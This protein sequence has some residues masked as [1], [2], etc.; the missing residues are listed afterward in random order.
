MKN[1]KLLFLASSISWGHL[2]LILLSYR[3]IIS[4]SI[5][6][7]HGLPK[8][9]DFDTEVATIPDPIG[10]G[11]YPSALIG[12]F[13]NLVCPIFISVGL[14]TRAFIIPIL[15]VTMMGYF[16]VHSGDPAKVK[17]IPFMYSVSFLMIMFTGPGKYSVDQY[18]LNNLNV[19]YVNLQYNYFR[20][21]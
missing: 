9:S 15:S 13:A 4:L 21:S 14:F 8:I 16:V 19:S 12:A 6:I 5:F 17:D 3:L 10:I 7:V 2:N 20:S 18:L 1:L 11:Q